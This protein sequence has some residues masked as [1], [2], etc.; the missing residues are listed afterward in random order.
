[1]KKF[2]QAFILV[3][4]L[5]TSC[6]TTSEFY[7]TNS[8]TS[9]EVA[10]I[11]SHIKNLENQVKKLENIVMELELRNKK[12]DNQIKQNEQKYQEIIVQTKQIK[13]YEESSLELRKA[14]QEL[15]LDVLKLKKSTKPTY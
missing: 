12:L 4:L 1:M 15:R 8:K 11:T 9:K 13:V 2:Y 3:L 7:R 14:V 6:V 10:S 5:F